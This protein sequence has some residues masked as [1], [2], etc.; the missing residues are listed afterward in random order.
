MRK[1]IISSLI[2]TITILAALG[3][4]HPPAAIKAASTASVYTTP[5]TEEIFNDTPKG[6]KLQDFVSIPEYYKN[7]KTDDDKAFKSSNKLYRVG[8]STYTNK[9]D[10]I[11]LL[12]ADST[13]GSQIGSFWGNVKGT[14]DNPTYNYFDLTKTQEVS[15]WV[16][17]GREDSNATDGFAFVL[18][19]DENGEQAISRSD[20]MPVGGQTLGVWGGGGS[21]PTT[22]L[23]SDYGGIKNSITIESI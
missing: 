4:L 18:Q 16:Y 14:V 21:D 8:N 13:Q 6:L 2:F 17:N 19:S 15:V 12:Q 3:S 22:S 7:T 20:G 1:R 11:Q 9:A 5:T 23:T 10:I